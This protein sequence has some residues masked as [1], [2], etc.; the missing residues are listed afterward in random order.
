VYDAVLRRIAD[1]VADQVYE[2][3]D[4]RPLLPARR[5]RIAALDLDP[6]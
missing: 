5:K 2:D 1:G 3:L 6:D 4:D